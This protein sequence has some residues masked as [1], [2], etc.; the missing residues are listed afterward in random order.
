MLGCGAR[1]RSEPHPRHDPQRALRPDEQLVEVGADGSR[2][3]AA[4]AHGAAVGEHDLEADD[5]VL[6]LPVAGRV[7]AC[8]ATCG[9]AADRGQIEA[10][11]E[12]ADAQVVTGEFVLEVRPERAGRD[13]DHAR[14]SIDAADAAE[15]G[16]VEQHSAER[17]NSA[18]RDAAASGDDSQ[19]DSLAV[20]DRG[21][22]GD[23]LRR[24]RSTDRGS[25]GT[26]RCPRAT[27]GERAAT[28]PGTLLPSLRRR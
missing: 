5:Q 3:G 4:G 25:R 14:L 9:P 7:L 20:A 12:V 6:D 18:A 16:D 8:A 10:L 26:A 28:N 11:R 1:M 2:R 21:D 22:R 23:L 15:P 19:R 24:R 17:W 13:L 27:S